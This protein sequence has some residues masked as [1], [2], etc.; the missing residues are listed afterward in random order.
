MNFLQACQLQSK[1]NNTFM[2]LTRHNLYALQPYSK[3]EMPQETLPYTHL[4][5][6]LQVSISSVISR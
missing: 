6:E 2:Y 5:A 1:W 3:Q 4:I